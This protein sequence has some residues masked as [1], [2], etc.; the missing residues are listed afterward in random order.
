M[1]NPDQRERCTA[2]NPMPKNALGRWEH[3]GAEEIGDAINGYPG[4]EE[5]A[6]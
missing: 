2:G 3:E 4:G 5:L 6:Q 1:F